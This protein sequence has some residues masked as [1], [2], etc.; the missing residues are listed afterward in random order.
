MFKNK[1]CLS[2]IDFYSQFLL[3]VYNW[4]LE[5]LIVVESLPIFTLIF[6]ICRT[7]AYILENKFD[8]CFA[9]D[10]CFCNVN[11]AQRSVIFWSGLKIKQ[12][13]ETLLSLQEKNGQELKLKGHNTGLEITSKIFCCKTIKYTYQ[14]MF[15][16][17]SLFHFF[18]NN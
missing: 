1:R 16:F 14:K 12:V 8:T 10:T 15:L 3:F 11:D 7:D 2:F 17:L 6:W 5:A 13:G 4:S 9:Q 18:F